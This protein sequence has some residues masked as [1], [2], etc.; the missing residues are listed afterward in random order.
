MGRLVITHSTYIQGLI[1]WLQ[2][3]AESKKIQTVTP[4]EIRTTKGRSENLKIRV[5]TSIQGGYKLIARKGRM[6]QEV[7]VITGLDK[8]DLI[9]FIKKAQ[10]K[11]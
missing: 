8:E 4:G 1:P 9:T 6:V 7:F 10:K 2:N 11:M 3:L 5:S